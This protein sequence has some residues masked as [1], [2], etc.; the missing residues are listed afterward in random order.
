M[1]I[2]KISA[3][4]ILVISLFALSCYYVMFD[5][6]IIDSEIKNEAN[7]QLNTKVFHSLFK[8]TQKVSTDFQLSNYSKDT[9]DFMVDNGQFNPS[10]KD[11]LFINISSG[12]GFSGVNLQI[13]KIWRRSYLDLNN[14]TDNLNS[15]KSRY[16]IMNYQLTLD[17]LNYAEGDS[18]F[19]KI[20]MQVDDNKIEVY[21]VKKYFRAKLKTD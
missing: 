10:C 7:K 1:K 5:H 9:V 19:G 3:L 21:D 15:Q 6:I 16:K 2:F 12:D 20:E 13:N 18:V 8:P 11:L 14:Y 17:Q 4:C